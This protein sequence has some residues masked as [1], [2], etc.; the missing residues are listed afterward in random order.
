[1]CEPTDDWSCKLDE[2]SEL[3]GNLMELSGIQTRQESTSK[4]ND[5]TFPCGQSAAEDDEE[6]TESK[7]KAFLDEKVLFSSI[8]LGDQITVYYF[9]LAK[10]SMMLFTLELIFLL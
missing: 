1:M 6:V 10:C 4:E 7:I 3:G 8:F 5:F 2:S 9:K